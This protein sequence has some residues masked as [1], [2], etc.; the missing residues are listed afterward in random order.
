MLERLLDGS[1]P[2]YNQVGIDIERQRIF[3]KGLGEPVDE[4]DEQQI[5]MANTKDK[6]FI[7][8]NL[9]FVDAMEDFVVNIECRRPCDEGQKYYERQLGRSVD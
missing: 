7:A 4:M 1:L 9:K 5:K 8:T 2:E 3:L 6:V